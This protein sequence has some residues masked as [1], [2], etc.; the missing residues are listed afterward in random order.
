MRKTRSVGARKVSAPGRYVIILDFVPVACAHAPAATLPSSSVLA[1]FAV[2]NWPL[3]L[4]FVLSGAMLLW[5]LLQRRLSPAREIGTLDA[6]RLM[7]GENPLVLDVREANE[8]SG[9]KLPNAV[10]IP[11]SQMKDR[12]AELAKHVARPVIV[13]CDRGSRSGAAVAELS[14][15]G[16]TRV[17]SLRGGLRAWKEAGLPLSK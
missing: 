15:L 2:K 13:Y 8:I 6:T 5:P 17:Q 10:H 4:V 1:S 7:N 11:M 14:R 9:G 12:G 16:F 3:V